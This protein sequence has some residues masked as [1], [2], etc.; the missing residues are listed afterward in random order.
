MKTNYKRTLSPTYSLGNQTRRARAFESRPNWAV[1]YPTDKQ[2]LG[3]TRL[4]HTGERYWVSIWEHQDHPVRCF[5][6]QLKAKDN[7]GAKAYRCCLQASGGHPD[8][9]AGPLQLA[10]EVIYQLAL[11]ED[12]R[13]LRI[14]FELEGDA[15]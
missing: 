3:V 7:P 8:Q 4:S 9:F 13:C 12:A 1:C 2:Y 14:H 15:K 11:W 10:N 5:E 6:V